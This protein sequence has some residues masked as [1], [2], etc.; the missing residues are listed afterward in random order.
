[1]DSRTLICK[2]TEQY[3]NQMGLGEFNQLGVM[4]E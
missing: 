4:S 2:L 1:M 3:W